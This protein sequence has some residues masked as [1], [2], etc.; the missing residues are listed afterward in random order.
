MVECGIDGGNLAAV[1]NCATVEA[2]KK[3]LVGALHPD[4]QTYAFGTFKYLNDPQAKRWRPQF[5]EYVTS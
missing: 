1:D 2:L 5:D 3:S 4:G